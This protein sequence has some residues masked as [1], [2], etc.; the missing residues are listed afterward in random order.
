M[1]KS[2]LSMLIPEA[3]LFCFVF[4]KFIFRCCIDVLIGNEKTLVCI[5]LNSA[6]LNSHT[7]IMC[8]LK[9]HLS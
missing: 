1:Y 7:C 5:F 2:S 4:R 8:K 6:Q 3:F 9:L